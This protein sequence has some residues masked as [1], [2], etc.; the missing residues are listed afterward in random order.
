M[1]MLGEPFSAYS[2]ARTNNNFHTS[3]ANIVGAKPTV[4][5]HGVP[6]VFGPVV[7]NPAL[8]NTVF[9]SCFQP[10]VR[11]G[12]VETSFAPRVTGISTSAWSNASPLPSG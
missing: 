11:T 9:Y 6:G 2:G 12:R 1:Y 4:D 8:A 7:F 10:S 3:R 5:Y